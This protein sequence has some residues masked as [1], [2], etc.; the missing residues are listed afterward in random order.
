MRGAIDGL[1][2]PHPVAA[3][4]PAIFHADRFAMGFCAG[5]VQVLAPVITTL[6]CLTAYFDPGTAPEDALGWLASWIGLSL[7]DAQTPQRQRELIAAGIELLSWR[8]TTTGITDAVRVL[9]DLDAEIV[10]SG[11]T[12]ASTSPGSRLP[13]ES[14]GRVVV[15]V[16]ARADLDVR[17]LDDLIAAVKPA[18][19]VHEIELLEPAADASGQGQ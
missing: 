9:F 16:P 10:D 14:V 17:Q 6:D 18:H 4:L 15:R 8:G 2:S 11:G 13:G 1:R 7:S 19:I 3:H 5:L 12:Q